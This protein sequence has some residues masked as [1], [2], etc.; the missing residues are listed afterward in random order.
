MPRNEFIKNMQD[1]PTLRVR[2]PFCDKTCG[3]ESWLQCVLAGHLR[4]V[5]HLRVHVFV[6]VTRE[7]DARV[8]ALLWVFRLQ[9]TVDLSSFLSCNLEPTRPAAQGREQLWDSVSQASQGMHFAYD[10]EHCKCH[11]ESCD[12]CFWA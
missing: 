5:Q 10:R 6:D 2:D 9:P 8:I 4:R 7:A 11:D 12:T 3:C 1:L